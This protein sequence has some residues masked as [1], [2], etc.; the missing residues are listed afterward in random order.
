MSVRPGGG[1]TSRLEIETDDVSFGY[2]YVGG[3][4]VGLE[5]AYLQRDEVDRNPGSGALAGILEEEPGK[6][7]DTL[8]Q[9]LRTSHLFWFRE[10][11]IVSGLRGRRSVG[12][13]RR[14]RGVTVSVGILLGRSLLVI[15]LA[16]VSAIGLLLLMMHRTAT[17]KVLAPNTRNGRK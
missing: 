2:V 4:A 7:R 17:S 11:Y 3:D 15:L 1:H 9:G 6:T 12:L 5:Y 10:T 14:L 16:R 8:A 13:L